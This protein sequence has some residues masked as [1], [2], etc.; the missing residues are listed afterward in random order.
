M[1]AQDELSKLYATETSKDVKK[2]ILQSMFISGR[3]DRLLAL[4]KTEAD[5]E[6]RRTAVRNLGLMG[7][8]TSGQALVD[9][10]NTEK[11]PGVRKGVIEGLFIQN[12]AEALVAL[13]RK[14]TDPAMK[15]RIVEKLALMRS[16]AAT[17]YIMEILK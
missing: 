1:G 2:Q 13:A 9:I 4:A 14:E 5:P 16:K 11:D 7:E 15:R 10:Y 12:N 6:L 17:D 3:G 8:S